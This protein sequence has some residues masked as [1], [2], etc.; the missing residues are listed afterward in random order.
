MASAAVDEKK[1]DGDGVPIADSNLAEIGTAADKAARKGAAETEDAWKGAGLAPG[2]NV[3][4]IEQ[5]KVVPWPKESY[6]NFHTGDSYIVLETY[7]QKESDKM[8]HNIYFWLGE[9]TSTDEMGTAAYKTVELDDL[10]DQEPTQNREVQG[11]ESDQFKR[12]FSH[13]TYLQGGV[14]SGFR[15]VGE[16]AYQ[17]KLFRVRKTATGVQVQE[18][19][20]SKDSMNHGDVFILD[21]GKTIY[22][23]EGKEASAFEKEAANIAAEKIEKERNGKATATHDIDEKFWEQL[24]GGGDIKSAAEAGDRVPEA[25]VGEGELYRLSDTNGT[26]STTLVARGDL[27]P[28][29]L[30]TNDV[31][32]LDTSTEIF[33]WVGNG[34]SP[35]E[36]RNALPT[37]MRFLKV[38]NRPT[39]TPIHVYKE[40]KIIDNQIWNSVFASGPAKAAAVEAT[41][42]APAKEAT[43]QRRWSAETDAAAGILTLAELQDSSTWQNK[44]VDPAHREM[45][46]SDEDFLSI[47]KMT[48]AEFEKLPKWKKD[49]LKKEQK[50]F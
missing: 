19:S 9:K 41:P 47:F 28:G 21:A 10:F 39:Q 46:L 20:C 29:M 25:T 2:L 26:L 38:N 7:K 23:W 43:T 6:G 36:Y 13:L 40:G 17:S 3:W 33:L 32:M 8:L 42:G 5:F 49:T 4:R 30:E 45:H 22:V 24:G 14:E 27:G 44:L 15:H 16:D 1:W 37:A 48:K 31:M 35:A 50:L 11:Y 12:L 34:A 18:V